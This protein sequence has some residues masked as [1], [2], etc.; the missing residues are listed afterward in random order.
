MQAVVLVK[1]RSGVEW[2]ILHSR[3]ISNNLATNEAALRGLHLDFGF[4]MT[5]Y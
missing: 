4:A 5:S 3:L 2:W 1:G